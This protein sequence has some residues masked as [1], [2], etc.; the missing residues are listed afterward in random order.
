M[1]INKNVIK[2]S[3]KVGQSNG[4]KLAKLKRILH[5]MLMHSKTRF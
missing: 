2:T 3:R 1:A 5:I 4:S